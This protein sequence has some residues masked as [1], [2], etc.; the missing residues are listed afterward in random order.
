VRNR[1][2]VTARNTSGYV[3]GEAADISGKKVLSPRCF[4]PLFCVVQYLQYFRPKSRDPEF[5]ELHP[6]KMM[7]F[8]NP[9]IFTKFFTIF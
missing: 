6:W 8:K 1:R 7:H 9:K 4:N 5:P 2:V 3:P